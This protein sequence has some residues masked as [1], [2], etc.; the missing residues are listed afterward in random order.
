[1]RLALLRLEARVGAQASFAMSS[2]LGLEFWCDLERAQGAS[3]NDSASRLHNQL[4]G[5][6]REIT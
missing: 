5:R 6:S 1:M 2:T 3:T 4:C